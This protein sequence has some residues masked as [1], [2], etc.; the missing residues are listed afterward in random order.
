MSSTR[1]ANR[2]FVPKYSQMDIYLAENYMLSS[3][4]VRLI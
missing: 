2:R 3:G 1:K 4:K